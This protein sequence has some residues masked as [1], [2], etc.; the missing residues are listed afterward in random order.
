MQKT[1]N[2]SK[3]IADE[4]KKGIFAG[5]KMAVIHDSL[6]R[7]ANC[8][9]SMSRFYDIYGNDIAEG[10]AEYQAWLGEV[11]NRRIEEGSD[12]ILELALRSK[13]GWNPSVKVEEASEEDNEE[14]SALN[15]LALLLKVDEDT[16]Q[17]DE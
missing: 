3:R 1:Y 15:K 16:D 14:T 2:H 11:A 13:A 5:L 6:L 10:R 7:D 4:I 9:R 8:P 17:E 12:K